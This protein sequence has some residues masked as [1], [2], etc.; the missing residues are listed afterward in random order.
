LNLLIRKQQRKKKV[1]SN[2]QYIMQFVTN[3]F[4]ACHNG[5]C[6]EPT[7]GQLELQTVKRHKQGYVRPL[8]SFTKYRIRHFHF[9]ILHQRCSR[10]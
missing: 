10:I 7:A 4:F 5:E 3:A 1:T 6:V 9:F 2:L 8:I